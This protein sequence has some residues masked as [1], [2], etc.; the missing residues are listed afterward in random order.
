MGSKW[1]I[2]CGSGGRLF[3]FPRSRLR[4]WPTAFCAGGYVPF[5][6]DLAAS[7]SSQSTQSFMSSTQTRRPLTS[8]Q[9]GAVVVVPELSALA[10]RGG[11]CAASRRDEWLREVRR[12][13]IRSPSTDTGENCSNVSS[14]SINSI[15]SINST[16]GS[17]CTIRSGKW[18]LGMD[19]DM[20][21]AVAVDNGDTGPG[22]RTG[23]P[24]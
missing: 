1:W 15:N 3:Q 23:R 9:N 20:D 12:G 19:P 7:T 5:S 14:G 10:G 18:R 21:L 8:S 24:S 17:G 4:R 11:T 6:Y 2:S 16:L 22:D 13:E